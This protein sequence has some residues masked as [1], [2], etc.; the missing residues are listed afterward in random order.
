MLH[1]GWWIFVSIV[2]S[3]GA[4]DRIL[5]Y[6]NATSFQSVKAAATLEQRNPPVHPRHMGRQRDEPYRIDLGKKSNSSHRLGPPPPPE[7]SWSQPFRPTL[8]RQR[9]AQLP[10]LE[11]R[12]PW[13]ERFHCTD[14][15]SLRGGMLCIVQLPHVGLQPLGHYQMLERRHTLRRPP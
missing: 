5:L 15:G 1:A 12:V 8:Q 13:A 14:G 11:H 6:E 2:P 4:S 7:L 9:A 10:Y 3:V